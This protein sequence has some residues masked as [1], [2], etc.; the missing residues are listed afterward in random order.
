MTLAEAIQLVRRD[1]RSRRTNCPAHDDRRP[2]LSVSRGDDG[3]ILLCCHRGCEFGQV[4]GAA[5]IDPRELA[6]PR[7]RTKKATRRPT[8]RITKHEIRDA[9]G[10]IVAIHERIDGPDG[11]RFVWRQP[12]GTAGLN[13]QHVGDLPLYGTHRL[14]EW[15]SDQVVVVVEGEKACEALWTVGIAALGTTTGAGGTPSDDVLRPL[16][17][18][19]VVLWPDHDEPGRQHMDR[20]AARLVAL[21]ARDV[22]IVE[23]P[24]AR[25]GGDA[26][27]LVA[28]G[29]TRETVEQLIASAEV[30][31]P[32]P[33]PDG[34]ALLAAVERFFTRYV[35]LPTGVPMALAVWTMATWLV[36]VF[37]ITPYLVIT[38]PEK[39]CG[40]TTVL[41]LLRHLVRAPLSTS[42]ISEAALFRIV[43]ERQPT[44]LV[45]EA[46]AL[47]ERSER[48]AALHDLLAAGHCRGTPAVRCVG[49]DHE[50]R[51][52]RVA[53]FKA[54]AL[55]GEPT[56][57]L[58]DRSIVVRMR[59]RAA[60]ESVE[61]YR[62][63]H[64]RHEAEPLRRQLEA[65]AAV[66][67]DAVEAAYEQIEPPAWLSDRA[68]D[69]WAALF[70]LVS[71]VAPDHLAELEAAAR[72]VEERDIE[73]ESI[74][75]RL[76]A[77]I[78][79]AFEEHADDRIATPVLL[80]AL[81][82]EAEA[83]WSGWSGGRGLTAHGLG[84]L[85]K[86]FGIRPHHGRDGNYYLRAS[87]EDAWTRYLSTFNPSQASQAFKINNLGVNSIL[88]SEPG[89]KDCDDANLL[90]GK[91]VKVVKLSGCGDGDGEHE[92]AIQAEGRGDLDDEEVQW[93][94]L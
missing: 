40:K 89:V 4:I 19:R 85:L 37:D 70:A 81:K 60:H 9:D 90:T 82:R 80:E 22:R 79:R 42:N 53:G 64:V 44:V 67:R 74:G 47:R 73:D 10:Q 33:A 76:L 31:R 25:P 12:D 69:N 92:R 83:P 17:G 13:G 50:P 23:W 24:D 28:A 41:H 88:H 30:W 52:F 36:E 16:I 21:G 20:L 54:L 34:A 5:G 1:G 94:D 65:W 38:S 35:V 3:R 75:V 57:I 49:K 93:L 6:P 46:Q 66:H 7:E 58:I 87:F 77:D 15:S 56:D 84:R 43:D 26:A 86:P 27:D 62:E 45:D 8:T 18:R 32:E 2:S 61:R 68:A 29:G 39:R 72:Q 71:V 14:A 63:R 59:R 51:E 91:A 11:K 48:S 78:K 55:V